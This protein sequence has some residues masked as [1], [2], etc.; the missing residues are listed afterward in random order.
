MKKIAF[1]VLAV[2]GIILSGPVALAGT[3]VATPSP[4][5]RVAGG[6][7]AAWTNSRLTPEQWSTLR[8]KFRSLRPKTRSNQE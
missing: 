5:V 8:P 4:M 3:P 2:G 7:H 1:A 6:E